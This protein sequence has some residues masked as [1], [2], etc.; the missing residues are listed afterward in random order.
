MDGDVAEKVM[1]WKLT[2]PTDDSCGHSVGTNRD[3]TSAKRNFVMTDE[4]KEIELPYFSTEMGDA[5]KVV[6]KTGLLDSKP[7]EGIDSGLC[8][9]RRSDGE[10]VVKYRQGV[11]VARAKTAPEVICVAALYRWLDENRVAPK[12][13]NQ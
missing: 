11:S 3:G 8:L 10:W 7:N 5:W 4:G 13:V 9:Q 12:P 2:C 6:E 1:G